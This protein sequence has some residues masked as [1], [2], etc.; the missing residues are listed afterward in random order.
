M[1]YLEFGNY[2]VTRNGAIWS[3]HTS[4]Y[5][6]IQTNSETGYQ[7]VQLF[8]EGEMVNAYVHQ[9][10]MEAFGPEKPADHYEI[11]HKDGDKTNNHL[12]NLEWVT[13][14]ENVYQSNW[15]RANENTATDYETA[16]KVKWLVNNVDEITIES[17]ADFFELAPETTLRYG[18]NENLDEEKPDN[19]PEIKDFH[20]HR[21][22]GNRLSLAKAGEIKW[23][24]DNTS[25]IQKEIS[26]MYNIPE[27]SV[28][29][30][31]TGD[32]YQQAPTIKPE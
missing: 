28:S 26:E 30:I 5:L 19:L 11:N 7:F 6:S 1:K 10:V 31:N 8:N 29:R 23:L 3:H 32:L 9:L 2:S 21:D 18:K 16:C 12:H 17:I 20:L 27:S 15:T 24:L 25:K 22:R 14:K 13:H 4:D